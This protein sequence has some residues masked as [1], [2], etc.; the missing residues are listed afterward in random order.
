ECRFV[1]IRRAATRAREV[2][3]GAAHV[4]IAVARG[5]RV[6]TTEEN[7]HVRMLVPR[8]AVGTRRARGGITVFVELLI[9]C[10]P[11]IPRGTDRLPGSPVENSFSCRQ[12]SP[13]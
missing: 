8:R 1:G 5:I 2:S 12:D 6:A 4:A 9:D 11:A 13:C 3:A 7:A 10:L